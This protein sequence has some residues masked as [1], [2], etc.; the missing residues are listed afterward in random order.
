MKIGI[1]FNFYFLVAAY[2]QDLKNYTDKEQNAI[3]KEKR[4]VSSLKELIAYKSL[5][6]GNDIQPSALPLITTTIKPSSP[7]KRPTGS[8]RPTGI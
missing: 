5:V 7:S 2:A 8:R 3:A 1:L 4:K 6:E